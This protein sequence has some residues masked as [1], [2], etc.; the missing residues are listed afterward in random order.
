MGLQ[1]VRRRGQ[2]FKLGVTSP[3]EVLACSRARSTLAVSRSSTPLEQPSRGML[4]L[5]LLQTVASDA[6][7]LQGPMCGLLPEPIKSVPEWGL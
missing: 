5:Q 7:R 1:G 3:V 4:K 6:N 2:G